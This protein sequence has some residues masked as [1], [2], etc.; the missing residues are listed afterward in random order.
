MNAFIPAF[1][2]LVLTPSN[3]CPFYLLDWSLRVKYLH[4]I[5]II[6]IITRRYTIH[7]APVLRKQTWGLRRAEYS[8]VSSHPQCIHTPAHMKIMNRE[9]E[10]AHHTSNNNSYRLKELKWFWEE[11][12]SELLV[13]T[14]SRKIEGM[15]G[16]GV[17]AL[18]L[19]NEC[20]VKVQREK[21][22]REGW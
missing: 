2:I 17:V 14:L 6:V 13:I 5:Y 21:G 10:R 3:L 19:L 20:K 8:L 18:V 12:S 1:L 9:K 16:G 4:T 15:V 22:W 11:N 7:F